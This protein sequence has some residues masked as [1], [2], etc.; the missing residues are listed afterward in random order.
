[1]NK[2]VNLKNKSFAIYGLGVTGTSTLN[3]FKKQ[4]IKNYFVWD[5]NKK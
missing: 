4:N 3:Y 5:D 1:M 2:P